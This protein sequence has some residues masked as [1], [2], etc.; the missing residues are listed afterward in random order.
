MN[1]AHNDSPDDGREPPT[2]FDPK[3]FERIIAEAW[4]WVSR[5][6]RKHLARAIFLLFVAIPAL[7][8]FLNGYSVLWQWYEGMQ[9]RSWPSRFERD[10]LNEYV[11]YVDS[12]SSID[13]AQRAAEQFRLDYSEVPMVGRDWRRKTYVVRDIR[14]ANSWAVV[15]DVEPHRGS[16][17]VTDSIADIV[18]QTAKENAD[19]DELE[20][21]VKGAEAVFYSLDAF[22]DRFGRI[23]G[24]TMR[25]QIVAKAERESL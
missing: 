22:E 2:M 15:V 17:N 4:H 20:Q 23:D 25:R 10:V 18:Y 21:W 8:A 16:Q 6:R 1:D 12:Y 5:G 24:R 19:W 9:K 14:F 3:P 13:A 11:L 7:A